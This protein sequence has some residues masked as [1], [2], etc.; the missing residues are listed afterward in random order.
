MEAPFWT[1]VDYLRK[2]VIQTL[3]T[4]LLSFSIVFYIHPR[5]LEYL[6][7][8][9]AN[10][11]GQ[12]GIKTTASL[13]LL[14][15]F[16]GISLIFHICFWGAAL[17]SLPILL[18]IWARFIFPGLRPHEKSIIKSS[19]IT[20]MLFLFLGLIVFLKLLLPVSVSTLYQLNKHIGINSWSASAYYQFTTS[21]LFGTCIVFLIIGMIL[22]L[23]INDILSLYLLK[24][25]RKYFWVGSFILSAI[26]TPPDILSQI[27]LAFPLIAVF[28]ACYMYQYLRSSKNK[29]KP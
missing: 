20:G 9:Y 26:V 21:L 22:Q 23:T 16:E 11:V 17:L 3:I 28:E 1:H 12:Q 8:A 19:A 29:K 5:L 27:A 4:L 13:I 6:N 10:V 25:M 14:S 7:E 24:I 2:S 18:T 15:P